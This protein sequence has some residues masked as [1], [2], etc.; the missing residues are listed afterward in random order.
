MGWKA[1]ARYAVGTSHKEQKTPCQDCGKYRIFNNVIVGAVADGAGSAKYSHFGS[2]LA[3]E[4]VIKCFA[5]INELPDKKSFS[6][7]LSEVEAKEVFAKFVNEVIK[8]FNKEADNK[9]Y[10]VSDLA[11]TLLVFIATPQWVAAMQ[12]GDGFM[13]VHRQDAEY[14]LLFEP[15]KGE[16]F[17]ETTFVTSANALEE[18]QVQVI[19]GKQGFICAS[20]DGLEKVAIRLSDWQPHA[21]FFK[22]LEEYLRET[23]KPEEDDKY[24]IDFLNSER[25]NSRTDDDKTLLLCCLEN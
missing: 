7:P 21:P 9:G 24:V 14:Q 18:M 23:D 20:T 1:I 22:P 13:V 10:S 16:F 25:L 19:S 2:E 17:N 5:D 6:Q 12:I 15:D 8:A 3:V 11:C 4:T